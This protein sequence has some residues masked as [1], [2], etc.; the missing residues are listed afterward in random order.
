MDWTQEYDRSDKIANVVIW[1]HLYSISFEVCALTPAPLDPVTRRR[2]Y[3]Q[4]ILS[5][6]ALP[7]FG[8]NNPVSDLVIYGSSRNNRPNKVFIL[9]IRSNMAVNW[10]VEGWAI[11]FRYTLFCGFDSKSDHSPYQW[12][13]PLDS[14]VKGYW[15][16]TS[17]GLWKLSHKGF[18]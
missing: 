2:K 12:P 5:G 17:P 16:L 11:Y 1:W 6:W 9:G 14:E 10:P 8:V 4:V 7:L 3:N 18:G 15:T 13:S